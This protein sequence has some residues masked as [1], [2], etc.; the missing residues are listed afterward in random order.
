MQSWDR[1]RGLRLRGEG[2]AVGK[3][4]LETHEEGNVRKFP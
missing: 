3:N 2:V 1:A 4:G